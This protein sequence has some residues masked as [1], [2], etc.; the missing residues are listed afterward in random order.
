MKEALGE[1][2]KDK[3]HLRG[4]VFEIEK[5]NTS[6]AEKKEQQMRLY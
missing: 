2:F 4:I 1:C 5:L 6:E 3:A